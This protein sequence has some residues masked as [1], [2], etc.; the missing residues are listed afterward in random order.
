MLPAIL[1]RP[2]S[3]RFKLF[4]VAALVAASSLGTWKLF[5][6]ADIELD[7]NTGTARRPLVAVQ[8]KVTQMPSGDYL[9]ANTLVDTT[10]C[11]STNVIA[12]NGTQFACAAA[13]GG[14]GGITNSA[15]NHTLTVS[16]G[17]N[18][19]SSGIG[20]DGSNVS[21]LSRTLQVGSDAVNAGQVLMF[22]KGV[23][24][25]T[26]QAWIEEHDTNHQGDTTG[27]QGGNEAINLV[28]RNHTTFDTSPLV[29]GANASAIDL[30]VDS[31]RVTGANPLTNTG[32]LISVVN[33][34]TNYGIYGL[35]GVLKWAEA[36]VF[37][38]GD[39]NLGAN[40]DN[41]EVPG[42]TSQ[43]ARV[44]IGALPSIDGTQL[45][46]KNTVAASSLA[47]IE[48]GLD[49]TVNSGIRGGYIVNRGAAGGFG[50]NSAGLVVAGGSG[51]PFGST[52]ANDLAFYTELGASIL[53]GADDS[54][55]TSATRLTKSNHWVEDA[56]TGLPTLDAGCTSGTGSGIVGNDNAFAVTTGTTSTACTVTF[57]KTWTSKPI[58]VVTP[59]A[60]ATFTETPSATTVVF[61]ANQSSKTY[62]VQ[63]L[64]QPNGT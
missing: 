22:T 24:R 18:V 20:D 1:R 8:G 13:G 6:A 23:S 63:C 32:I 55:F 21:L 57:K 44:G 7:I 51:F 59:D 29:P 46:T 31:S 41:F 61:S 50:G 56:S 40:V 58:C 39:V 60:G 15:P 38:P 25:T 42:S 64:G 16:D 27:L 53:F 45:Q 35:H 62:N 43:V 17:T 47:G 26:T 3:P 36:V 37:G 14:G 54:G 52:V 2:A 10:G 33:G 48:V 34:D 9:A 11:S 30:V 4:V 5:H 12:W 19:G 49:T 28:L